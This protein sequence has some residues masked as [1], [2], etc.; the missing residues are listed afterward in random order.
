MNVLREQRDLFP[1]SA[2][3]TEPA[4]VPFVEGREHFSLWV[5]S[6]DGPWPEF[7]PGYHVD[8]RQPSRLRGLCS[9]P[10]ESPDLS[11]PRIQ[12]VTF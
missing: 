5:E 10:I 9:P 6:A 12:D 2:P 7:I 11:L 1:D 3:N 8:V 4:P